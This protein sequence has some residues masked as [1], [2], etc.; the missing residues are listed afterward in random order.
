[1]GAAMTHR[2]NR[3]GFLKTAAASGATFALASAL[4]ARAAAGDGKL[5]IAL[6]GVGERGRGFIKKIAVTQQSLVAICDADQWR[7]DRA[8]ALP[9][10][11]RVYKDFRKLLSELGDSIDAVIIATPH[12]TQ[13]PISAA[14][15]RAGKHVYC[16]KP[17]AHDVG[18]ARDIRDLV[19]R[20]KL[21]TQMGNQGVSTDAFRRILEQ[22]QDGAIGEIREVYQWYVAKPDSDAA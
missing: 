22:V 15:I 7:I 11:T 16:E 14:A 13:P 4:P 21:I 17:I 10:D 18:E 9:R 1:M 6:I 12:H 2:T 19:G 3:R 8:G 20:H 5:R